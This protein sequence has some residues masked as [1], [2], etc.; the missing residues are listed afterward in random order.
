[1]SIP[2]GGTLRSGLDKI[3]VKFSGPLANNTATPT[4]TPTVPG[5]WQSIGP[6][7]TFTPTNAFLPCQNYT[8]IVPAQT[9]IIKQVLNK[10]Y[11]RPFSVACPS[12]KGLQ[13]ALTLLGYLPYRLEGHD[14]IK[15]RSQAA[16]FAYQTAGNLVRDI[17]GAPHINLSYDDPATRGA[18]MNF[19]G[20]H[21]L[22]YDGVAGQ[23][24]WAAI[25]SALATHKKNQHP[26]T[27]VTVSE[28][29]PET[30]EVHI[31]HRT[32]ITT[33]VNTGIPGAVTAIGIYPI[34]SRYVS[35][36]MRGT[37]PDGSTYVAPD[38]PWVNYFNGGD[39]VHG[40]PRAS[41]GT[42]QSNG[43]VELPIPTAAKVFPLLSIGDI[44]TV[45]T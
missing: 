5:K 19:Q 4:F 36:T 24:T 37:E 20:Q 26:Y 35:T 34:Y 39:A 3:S 7:E 25:L 38:V 8:I 13:K 41:Y 28:N 30:L 42:P 31:G 21:G 40:Y 23:T 29:I 2:I 9:T 11:K 14:Q 10:T 43:C 18:V 33:P 22:N 15:T 32:A 45:S 12:A 1:M 16:R 27:W 6:N 44:V 17:P